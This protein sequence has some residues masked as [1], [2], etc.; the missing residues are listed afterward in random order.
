MTAAWIQAISGV[1]TL[2]AA[3][4]A[5]WIASQVPKWSETLRK[6]GRLSEQSDDLKRLV[7]ISLMKGRNAMVHADTLAAINLLDVAFIDSQDVKEARRNFMQAACAEPFSGERLVERF[8]AII[9]CVVREMGLNKDITPA[10]IQQGYYPRVLGQ[11]DEA[12]I[13][14]AEEKL[15]RRKPI[16]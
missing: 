13:A 12:A 8:H 11:L 10:D 15:A 4:T 5:A 9:V 2:F 7:L 6:S 1:L 3:I 14:E 16:K